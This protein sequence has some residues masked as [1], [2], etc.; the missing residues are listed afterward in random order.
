MNRIIPGLQ[1][2]LD[3]V[4]R[5]K[6]KGVE[7][8][9]ARVV[10]LAATFYN[11]DG[12]TDDPK[13]IPNHDGVRWKPLLI[14]LGINRPCYVTHP[15]PGPGFTH[16]DFS[17]GGHV[18]TSSTGWVADGG[19]C[20]LVPMCSWHNHKNRDGVAFAHNETEVVEL[21]GYNW[22]EPAAL[23][24]LR[25][26]SNEPYAV[27]YFSK[28]S[29]EFVNLSDEQ[30]KN[31]SAFAK[32]ITGDEDPYYVLFER[33]RGER[34]L[35]HIRELSL[36]ATVNW[37]QAFSNLVRQTHANAWGNWGLDGSIAVGAV[38]Y[39]NPETGSFV[40]VTSIDPGKFKKI[41]LNNA[42]DWV[43]E[44]SGTHRSDASV[45]FAGGYLDPSSGVEVTVGTTVTWGFNETMGLASN[46][47]VLAM[48]NLDNFG[49][50][51]QGLQPWLAQ[52]AKSVGYGDGTDIAQGF[53]VITSTIIAAG[54]VNVGSEDAG[55]YFSITGSVD[56]VAEMTGDGSATAKFGGSYKETNSNKSLDSHI[57]PSKA[58]TRADGEVAIAFNFASFDGTMVLPSWVQKL[59]PLSINFDNAHGGTYIAEIEVT[60]DYETEGKIN[61]GRQTT[62]V[63]GGEQTSISG[64]PLNATNLYVHIH[65]KA[66]DDFNFSWRI[67]A[68]TW[69]S[70]TKTID[71]S[72]VWPWG[73]HASVRSS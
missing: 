57:Y 35:H 30:A 33:V 71:L 7:S 23:F 22:G 58:N 54:V 25:L 63:S 67:P 2:V 53:G 12:S 3:F 28:G 59:D 5:S 18:T 19:T 65:F 20:Y 39:V 41:R 69:L 1:N 8:T 55:N 27:L 50:V 43:L 16:P 34:V 11:V 24:Q 48:E 32:K 4:E 62:S 49:V 38:G 44:S 36:P 42:Q 26:P 70:D 9:G 64:I 13:R 47:S 21:T 10:T 68:A 66:G 61:K 6:G 14:A 40:Q 73:S 45:D 15:I 17:V 37:N 51:L 56:G 72:G 31:T 52:I 29:W 60:Y 46:C